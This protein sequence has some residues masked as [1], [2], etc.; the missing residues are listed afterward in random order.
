M[1]MTM[2]QKI[3]ADHAGLDKVVP[4]Q[5]INAKLDIVLGNDY[6]K[7]SSNDSFY[8]V[9]SLL[10]KYYFEVLENDHFKGGYI[11]R[12]YGNEYKSCEALQIEICYKS[13]ICNREYGNEEMPIINEETFKNAQERMKKFFNDLKNDLIN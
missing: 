12:Y 11:T 2:T 10:N 5:L 13:Y 9:K 6:G 8:L 1:G 4:G 7:T 3:L